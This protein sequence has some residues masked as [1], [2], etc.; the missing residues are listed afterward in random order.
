MLL[1]LLACAPDSD[2]RDGV[3]NEASHVEVEKVFGD[4]PRQRPLDSDSSPTLW[5]N[6]D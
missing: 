5:S 3:K 4:L 2:V 6:L 1:L